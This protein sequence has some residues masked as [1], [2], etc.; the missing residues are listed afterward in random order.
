MNWSYAM[1]IFS[2]LVLFQIKHFFA[3]F[4]LQNDYMLGKFKSKGWVAPLAAHCTVHA[5]LTFYISVLALFAVPGGF[6]LAAKLAGFDFLVHFLMDRIKAS[7]TLLGRFKALSAMDYM[8]TAANIK[9]FDSDYIVG[10]S[11]REAMRS[12]TFFWWA[13]GLDQMV[14]HLTHYF[15]IWCLL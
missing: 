4:P 9:T 2:F 10:R 12:N 14:H 11:A 1:K 6:I 15:I 13:L 7:P 3:D 8:R 5:V